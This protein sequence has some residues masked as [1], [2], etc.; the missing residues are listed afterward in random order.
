LTETN[1]F[2]DSFTLGGKRI[3][4]HWRGPGDLEYSF[5]R[6]SSVLNCKTGWGEKTKIPPEA[7]ASWGGRRKKCWAGGKRKRVFNEDAGGEKRNFGGAL[8]SSR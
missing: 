4:R 5:L 1:T 7:F 3:E 8:G 2:G 6:T